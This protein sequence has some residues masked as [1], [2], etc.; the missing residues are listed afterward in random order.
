MYMLPSSMDEK[1]LDEFIQKFEQEANQFGCLVFSSSRMKQQMVRTKIN[2]G[3]RNVYIISTFLEGPA[4][5]VIE[6]TNFLKLAQGIVLNY[7]IL[8]EEAPKPEMALNIS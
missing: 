5:V 8:K 6:L 4:N 2:K 1:A 7:M 3:Q